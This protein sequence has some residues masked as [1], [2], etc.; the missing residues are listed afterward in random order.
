EGRPFEMDL[1]RGAEFR[2]VSPGYFHTLGMRLLRGRFLEDADQE[3]TRP[4]AVVNETLARAEWP[5]ENPLGK[6]IR[7]LNKAP[8][9]ATTA[10][11][12]VIG[13]VADV[14][15]GGLTGVARQEVYVSLRQ[16]A[17]GVADMD[18]PQRMTL[19]VRASVDPMNLANSIRQEVWVNDRNVPI[20]DV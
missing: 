10:F 12:T 15:S 17:A 8:E 9:R 14:K 13:V 11:L 6:R 18:P 7:L 19:A 16:R 2:V 5:N 1:R 3:H 20:T 4:V